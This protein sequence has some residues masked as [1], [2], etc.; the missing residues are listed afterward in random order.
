[1]PQ[2]S[3]YLRIEDLDKWGSL[4]SKARFV[5]EALNKNPTGEA[6][7]NSSPHNPQIKNTTYSSV[8]IINKLE[9]V[10]DNMPAVITAAD[11][12][13]KIKDRGTCRKCGSILSVNKKC[14][15]KGCK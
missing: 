4:E 2:V 3:F 13:T 1:M 9:I 5:H 14:L 7:H 10:K 15:M 12:Q 6:I 8:D 11:L